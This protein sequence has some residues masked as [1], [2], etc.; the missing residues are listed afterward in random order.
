MIGG[1]KEPKYD[2]YFFLKMGFT[3]I[4]IS[5]VKK[6]LICS[7]LIMYNLDKSSNAVPRV[8]VVD[9][10]PES[11]KRKKKSGKGG[12]KKSRRD[13][14]SSASSIEGDSE[15]NSESSDEEDDN[16]SLIAYTWPLEDR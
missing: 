12:K 13:R 7:S 9:L 8:A 1:S 11:S 4:F 6:Q 5:L 2:I 14:S 15:S 3:Y 10:E 16:W